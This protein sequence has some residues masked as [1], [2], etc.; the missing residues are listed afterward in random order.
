MRYFG[1]VLSGNLV[2]R[3][4]ERDLSFPAVGRGGRD[5]DAGPLRLTTSAQSL[6]RRWTPHHVACPMELCRRGRIVVSV[7]GRCHPRV[8]TRG[9]TQPVG[10]SGRGSCP[11]GRPYVAKLCPGSGTAHGPGLP[12]KEPGPSGDCIWDH[13]DLACVVAQ[14]MCTI[15]PS[16]VCTPPLPGR[17]SFASR[18][19]WLKPLGVLARIPQAEPSRVA[20]N[21]LARWS[22]W[23]SNCPQCGGSF[24]QRVNVRAVNLAARLDQCYRPRC[25]RVI[26]PP[27]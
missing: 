14:V 22:L 18:A 11:L 10:V 15:C 20:A 4:L 25:C 16:Q 6:P 12:Q 13:M 27:R 5:G 8:R 1:G 24:P 26:Y 7:C 2:R 3:R 9:I 17:G 19:Q 21:L 23:S